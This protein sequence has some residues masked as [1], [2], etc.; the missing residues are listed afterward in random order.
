MPRMR[1]TVRRLMAVVAVVAV[2]LG[3]LIPVL[4]AVD[5]IAHGPNAGVFNQHFEA[6]A[7]RAGLVGSPESGVIKVLGEPTS[8]W[9]YWSSIDSTTGRPS[10]GAYLI[11]TCNYAALPLRPMR[12]IPGPLQRRGR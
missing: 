3:V 5:A 12:D 6:L 8:V 2:I 1:F 9:K 10:A 11:T 4:Q 7:N